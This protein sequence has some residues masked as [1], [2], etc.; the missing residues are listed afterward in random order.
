MNTV[1]NKGFI[2]VLLILVLAFAVIGCG[3]ASPKDGGGG[4]TPIPVEGL[5]ENME[6]LNRSL[7]GDVLSVN[8]SIYSEGGAKEGMIS[9]SDVMRKICE[10]LTEVQL[11]EETDVAVTDS[12]MFISVN[13]GSKELTFHFEGD[14]LVLDN[15]KRYE[16]ENIDK[17]KAYLLEVTDEVT[18]EET[19]PTTPE[20]VEEEESDDK[21]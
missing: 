21:D 2:I 11:K 13:L 20:E 15:G 8:Y 9:D 16:V 18:E 1:R 7:N 19:Q 6:E 14:I 17:L 10:M 4:D 5:W 3:T 12:D